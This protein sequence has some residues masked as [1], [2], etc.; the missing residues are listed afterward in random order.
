MRAKLYQSSDLQHGKLIKDLISGDLGILTKRFNIMDGWGHEHPIW[1]WDIYWTG[2][3]SNGPNRTVA[4]V[5]FG[6]LGLLNGGVWLLLE[7]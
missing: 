5:E 2:P 7:P 1:A 6:I 4:F 3:S